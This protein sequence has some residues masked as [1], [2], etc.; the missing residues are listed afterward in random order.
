MKEK[1]CGKKAKIQT[2]EETKKSTVP[3]TVLF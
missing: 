2:N 1:K 3:G